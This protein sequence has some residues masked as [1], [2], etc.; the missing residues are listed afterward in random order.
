MFDPK[1]LRPFVAN[2]EVVAA[3]LFQ[4]IHREAVGG[5]LDATMRALVEQLPAIPGPG[6]GGSAVMN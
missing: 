1:G 5:V 3:S 6:K 4:R 2:W